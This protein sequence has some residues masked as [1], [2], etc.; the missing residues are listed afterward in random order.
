MLANPLLFGAH[1][2]RRHSTRHRRHH[3]L[4]RWKLLR[5]HLLQKRRH[6][7]HH[8]SLR[9]PTLES[10]YAALRVLLHGWVSHPRG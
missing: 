6:I 10:C 4:P 7:L 1:L 9:P 2:Q 5:R 3:N 8:A